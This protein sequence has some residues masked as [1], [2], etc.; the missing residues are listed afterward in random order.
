MT[1]K[2]VPIAT[3]PDEMKAVIE[4]V[5]RGMED[6]IEL[7]KLGAQMRKA[8]YDAHIEEGFTPEQALE[9]CRVLGG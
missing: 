2:I 8:K 4:V 3:K 1:D 5:R 9:F 7:F 6:Q